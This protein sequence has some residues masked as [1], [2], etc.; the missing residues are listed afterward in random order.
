MITNIIPGP[1]VRFF[2]TWFLLMK[3]IIRKVKMKRKLLITAA[4][5]M[6]FAMIM[7]GCNV[8]ESEVS[9]TP[10]PVASS[11]P[12]PTPV[13][14]SYTVSDSQGNEITFLD[15]PETVVS[16]A[17]NIT[18]IIFALGAQD[19]LLAR[20]DWCN[21]PAEVF[22]YE[23]VGN[24]DQ[25]DV[26]K[27]IS[28]NPDLVLLSEITSK[29]LALQIQNAG[30]PYFVVDNEETFEGAYTCIEMVGDVLSLEDEADT[31]VTEMKTRIQEVMDKVAGADKKKVYYVM[32]YGEYGDFT[33]GKGTFIS[34]MINSCGA[35]NVAD[36]TEGWSYSV[37]KLVEHNPDVLLLSMWASADGLKTANGYKDMTAVKNGSMYTLDDDSL[38]RLG[39]RIADAFEAMAAA[40]HPEL[41][42]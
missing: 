41:F 21:Y 16:L 28:L 35:V 6:T 32:G 19:K 37:E 24:I 15:V 36:D 8:Q 17:P 25:P 20:T 3:N 13:D 39:P 18:E 31:I 22:D 9:S 26:E 34:E 23:S 14:I 12:E 33:A 11:T 30:I 27:I 38:Q 42:E 29:E 2:I 10:A 5:V 7:A 40:I 1:H 4:I